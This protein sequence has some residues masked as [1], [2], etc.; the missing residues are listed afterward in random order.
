[1]QHTSPRPRPRAGRSAAP[2]SSPEPPRALTIGAGRSGY[3]KIGHWGK[4]PRKLLAQS[5]RHWLNSQRPADVTDRSVPKSWW[6]VVALGTTN[7][8][9][10]RL[11]SGR[12]G[13]PAVGTDRRHAYLHVRRLDRRDPPAVAER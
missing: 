5:S 12:D 6:L 9:D 8:Q 10:L 7:H 13:E 2:R 1:P 3:G 11:R 4:T